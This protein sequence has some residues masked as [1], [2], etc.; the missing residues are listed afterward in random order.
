M[1]YSRESLNTA[2]SLKLADIDQATGL[3]KGL[4]T[5]SQ[6]AGV[7]GAAGAVLILPL[8]AEVGAIA[9]FAGS[10]FYAISQ[11]MQSKR[12]GHFLPLPGVPLSSAQITHGV[13]SL[14][15]QLMGSEPPATPEPV[16]LAATDWLPEKERRINYLLTHCPDLIIGAAETCQ[17]GISLAAIVDTAVRASEFAITDAQIAN[18]I[19]GHKLAPQVRAVL[20]GDTSQLE[21]QQNRAIAQEYRRAQSD[22][23]AGKITADEFADIEADFN[24]VVGDVTALTVTA[25]VVTDTQQTTRPAASG[26][27]DVRHDWRDVFDLVKDQNLY[28]AVVVIGAQGLGKTTLVNYLLSVIKNRDKIVL[29]PHYAAG[30]WPGCLVIGAGMDYGAVA[31]ALANISADVKERY[32]QRACDPSYLPRPVTLI[33]EEQTNWAAKV[34]GAGQ[35]LKESLSDV[36]KVGYQTISVA[37]SDTNTARGG[38]VGTSKMREQGELKITLLEQGLAEVSLKGREKFKVRYPDPTPYTVNTGQPVMSKGGELGPG[39]IGTAQANAQPGWGNTQMT[40]D[41]TPQPTSQVS[42]WDLCKQHTSI[43]GLR[44]LME[45]IE[46]TTKTQ[47]TPRDAQGNKALRAKLP[48]SSIEA[49][50]AH[51]IYLEMEGFLVDVGEEVYQLA[52]H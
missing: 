39:Y 12:I 23:A 13:S 47:F 11:L 52:Q 3:H 26:G 24:E 48:D 34:A 35:F 19:T 49:V 40:I 42:Q 29:D 20:A 51:M 15:S 25:Q 22:L 8:A 16:R 31:D 9:L 50:R 2:V 33:L 21:A 44:D 4:F 14:V 32:Q 41:V 36:R 10:T 5:T 38:A 46:T 30:S 43:P 6:V 28:P 17:D 7:V 18:P 1:A 45:W 27:D 37:H